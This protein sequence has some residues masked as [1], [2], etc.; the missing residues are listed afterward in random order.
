MKPYPGSSS[1]SMITASPSYA[2]KTNGADD[3]PLFEIWIFVVGVYVPA[4]K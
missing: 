2:R 4:R 3:V 1:P